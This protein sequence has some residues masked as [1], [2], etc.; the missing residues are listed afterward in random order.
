ME[1]GSLNIYCSQGT[2]K[3]N[4]PRSYFFSMKKFLSNQ[5]DYGRRSRLL[6]NHASRGWLQS[7][8]EN[9][10]GGS[11]L[12]APSMCQSTSIYWKGVFTCILYPDFYFWCSGFSVSA[13]GTAFDHLS[14]VAEGSF[15]PG[16]HRIV[17]IIETFLGRLLFPRWH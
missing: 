11:Y 17:A 2:A 4:R 5:N 14:L 3:S 10:E 7:L 8:P 15:I 1:K 16:F 6:I 13:Q 12:H 9:S